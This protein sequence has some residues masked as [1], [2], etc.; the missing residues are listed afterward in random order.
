MKSGSSSPKIRP[1]G[2][3]SRSLHRGAIGDSLDGRS[4]EGRFLRQAERELLAQIGGEPTF[5]QK[6]LVRRV[7][8]MTF[9]AE[10][11]D[12][13]L[14]DG[15]SWSPH[16]ARTFGALNT[17]IT[18]AL[19]DLGLKSAPKPKANSSLADIIAEHEGKAPA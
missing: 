11:L 9:L 12:D 6:L 1:L 18:R 5:A 16:D 14:T 8:K 2:P 10:K 17:A 4:R 15:N 3:Y 13:K 19:R 7:A